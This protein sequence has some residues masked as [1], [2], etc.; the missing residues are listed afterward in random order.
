MIEVTVSIV[1]MGVLLAA[2]A[3]RFQVAFERSRVDLAAAQLRNIWSVQ[4]CF[5]LENGRYADQDSSADLAAVEAIGLD[6]SALAEGSFFTYEFHST[7]TGGFA[8]VAT[9]RALSA[10]PRFSGTL[11]I[12]ES[13]VIAGAIVDSY[14]SDTDPNYLIEPGYL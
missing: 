9:R 3:P 5:Y 14:C 12:D 6:T 8:A 13:G 11:S 2:T 4:R 1:V 7:S 10:T